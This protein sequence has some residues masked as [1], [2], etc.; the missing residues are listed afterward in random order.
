MDN[1]EYPDNLLQLSV[2]LDALSHPARL[3]VVEYLA[4]YQECPVRCWF[5]LTD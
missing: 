3:K 4:G 2:L 5:V 1:K